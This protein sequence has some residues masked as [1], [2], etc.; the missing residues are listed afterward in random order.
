MRMSRDTTAEIEFD[1]AT[2]TRPQR[3]FLARIK[4]WTVIIEPVAQFDVVPDRV[5]AFVALLV[6]EAA[7]EVPLVR[8]RE[9]EL[10]YGSKR[11]GTLRVLKSL[12]DPSELVDIDI[13]AEPNQPMRRIEPDQPRDV[14]EGHMAAS[15]ANS[16]RPSK[17]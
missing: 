11:L 12:N 5:M 1:I 6:P 13:L 3:Q 9:Y 2:E 10:M 16:T 8:G 7:V 4:R 14:G 17:S 15:R